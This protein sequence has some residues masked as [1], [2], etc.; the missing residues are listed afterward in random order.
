MEVI[1]YV[2]TG[3]HLKSKHLLQRDKALAQFGK[4]SPYFY[5]WRSKVQAS[6]KTCKCQ[7]Y[8][9]KV[10]SLRR[11]NVSRWLKVLKSISG[12]SAKDDMWYNR[13]L[14]PN[15]ADPLGTLC[16]KKV[17]TILLMSRRVSY[18]RWRHPGGTV[19]NCSRGAGALNFIKVR[20]FPARTALRTFSLSHPPIILRWGTFLFLHKSACVRPLP[21]KR[22]A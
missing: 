8:E 14:D 15:T 3:W 4:D 20:K 7:F 13:L 11:T 10:K 2:K 21:K 17:T 9:R 12:V 18:K 1:K 16:E 19:L 6:I 5:T 22:P